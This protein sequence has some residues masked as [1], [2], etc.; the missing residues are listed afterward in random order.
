MRNEI[1]TA[2]IV[3]IAVVVMLGGLGYYFTTLDKPREN[4]VQNTANNI[5]QASGSVTNTNPVQQV[6]ESQFPLVPDLVAISGYVNT[7]PEDLK[8]AMKGKRSEERRVGKEC[9]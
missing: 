7:T 1:K 8:S 6:D 9:R 3:G 2:I 4:Q 5:T